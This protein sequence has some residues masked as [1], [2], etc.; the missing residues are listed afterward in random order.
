[1]SFPAA[2]GPNAWSLGQYFGGPTMGSF[3]AAASGPSAL[4]GAANFALNP[5]TSSSALGLSGYLG[6]QAN[7]LPSMGGVGPMAQ[8]WGGIGALDSLFRKDVQGNTNTA[9]SM[10]GNAAQ[11][12]LA[13][14]YFGLPWIGAGIGALGGTK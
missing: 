13:G 7:M 10:L 8:L 4:G 9:E 3:G 1:M 12:A 14:S 5:A 11:G 2:I 6:G